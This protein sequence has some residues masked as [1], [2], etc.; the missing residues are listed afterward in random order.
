MILSVTLSVSVLAGLEAWQVYVPS[1]SSVVTLMV[2]ALPS[3]LIWTLGPVTP[4]PSLVQVWMGAGS[5]E[6]MQVIVTVLPTTTV[7]AL[8][9]AVIT[10]DTVRQQQDLNYTQCFS[11]VAI[12]ARP[13]SS[14]VTPLLT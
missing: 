14:H 12:L 3:A 1:S 9:T 4:T 13:P 7:T 11:I 8:S 6:A 5:P 2:R 10:G